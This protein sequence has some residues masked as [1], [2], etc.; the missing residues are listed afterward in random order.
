MRLP[1]F[2]VLMLFLASG[3]VMA[4]PYQCHQLI[5]DLANESPEQ[6]RSTLGMLYENEVE[7]LQWELYDTAFIEEANRNQVKESVVRM[8][9]ACNQPVNANRSVSE[10]MHRAQLVAWNH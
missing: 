9:A 2:L 1:H 7:P 3:S 8:A 6:M 4:A 5:E 10:V